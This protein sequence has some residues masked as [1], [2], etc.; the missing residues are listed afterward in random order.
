MG[1]SRRWS[2]IDIRPLV[3]SSRKHNNSGESFLDHHLVFRKPA[4]TSRTT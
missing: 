4:L 1:T 2:N 3:G